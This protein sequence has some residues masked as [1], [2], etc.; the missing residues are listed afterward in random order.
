MNLSPSQTAKLVAGV[1]VGAI[2]LILAVSLLITWLTGDPTNH[3]EEN[4]PTPSPA[5]APP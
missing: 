2:V 1:V 4:Q 5:G 3:L